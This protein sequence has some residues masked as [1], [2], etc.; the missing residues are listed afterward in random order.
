MPAQH[1][2]NIPPY[3]DD[4]DPKSNFNRSPLNL[5]GTAGF[6][7]SGSQNITREQWI[8]ILGEAGTWIR[9]HQRNYEK[10]Y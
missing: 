5:L 6:Q 8:D 3:N 10:L 4:W 1:N 7:E 9:K 2:L